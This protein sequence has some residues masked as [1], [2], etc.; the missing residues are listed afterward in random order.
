MMPRTLVL[1]SLAS[2]ALAACAPLPVTELPPVGPQPLAVENVGYLIVNSATF[3]H[4]DA[5]VFRYPHTSYK[6]YRANG[7]FIRTVD[8]HISTNDEIPE[9]VSLPA[10]S[11]FIL[12]ESETHGHVKVPIRIAARRTTVVN[13]ERR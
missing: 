2:L 11:Y 4:N 8:N 7:R 1:A 10:G 12:A 6:L 9:T 5:D 3:E 13:L